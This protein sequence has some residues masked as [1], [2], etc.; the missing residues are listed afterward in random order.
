M[1]PWEKPLEKEIP[2]VLGHMEAGKTVGK[3]LKAKGGTRAPKPTVYRGHP[4]A[5]IRFGEK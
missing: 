1:R 2:E 3:A 4:W 5:V